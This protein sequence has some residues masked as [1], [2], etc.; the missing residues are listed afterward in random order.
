MRF[1]I[2]KYK[3]IS[4]NT[5]CKLCTN[6]PFTL[7]TQVEQVFYVDDNNA[8]G[9]IIPVRVR[10]RDYYNMYDEHLEDDVRDDEEPFQDNIF[11]V[12]IMRE[13]IDVDIYEEINI[14]VGEL[15]ERIDADIYERIN[16]RVRELIDSD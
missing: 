1:K 4:L 9:W 7:A 5:S 6:E 13:R 2:D 14:R 8:E 15:I 16:I 10:P 3:I 11:D 12:P